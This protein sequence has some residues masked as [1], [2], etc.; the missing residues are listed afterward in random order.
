MVNS[1]IYQK[2]SYIEKHFDEEKES[3]ISNLEKLAKALFRADNL[4]VSYTAQREGLAILDKQ[5]PDFAEHLFT[6]KVSLSE[7]GSL[8]ITSQQQAAI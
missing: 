8:C 3:L 1:K 5:L 2:V 7:T 6:E 4:M